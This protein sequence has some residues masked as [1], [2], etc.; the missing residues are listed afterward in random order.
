MTSIDDVRNGINKFITTASFHQHDTKVVVLDEVDY[1]SQN[2][3]AM[4]RKLME[5]ERVRSRFILICNF[6]N[7]IIPPIHS[8]CAK[9]DIKPPPINLVKDRMIEILKKEKITF[10][11]KV[12]NEIINVTYPDFRAVMNLVQLQ[13][14]G[15]ELLELDRSDFISNDTARKYYRM[16]D[17]LDMI[18]YDF[19]YVWK[20]KE[21]EKGE[22]LNLQKDNGFLL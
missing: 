7:K 4:L 15:S 18:D 21:D 3:Q 17:L 22:L 14:I 12:L 20:L 6:P 11:D 19:K 10:K 2:A 13:S 9:I 8:R 1:M 16:L 5:E